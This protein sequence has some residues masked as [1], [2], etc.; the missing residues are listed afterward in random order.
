M[1]AIVT[2]GPAWYAAALA[3]R[4]NRPA[5]MIAPMQRDQVERAER[6]FQRVAVIDRGL[7]K[8]RFERLAFP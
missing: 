8:Q 6:L 2:A 3:V 1:N 4:T 5:P 7:G